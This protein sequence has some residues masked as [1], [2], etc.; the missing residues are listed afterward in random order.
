MPVTGG[1]HGLKDAP[2]GKGPGKLLPLAAVGREHQVFPGQ[3][4]AKATGL[5]TPLHPWSSL[6]ALTRWGQGLGLALLG[7]IES[8]GKLPP[9]QPWSSF[10]SRSAQTPTPLQLSY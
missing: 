9:S 4:G 8:K 10:L 5:A 1:E 2:G 3:T 6:G 7:E